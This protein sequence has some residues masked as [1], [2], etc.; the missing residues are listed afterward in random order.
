MI[1]SLPKLW[2]RS[3]YDGRG[4]SERCCGR[5]MLLSK[6]EELGA[7]GEGQFLLNV[8]LAQ[9]SRFLPNILYKRCA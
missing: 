1:S 9:A 4:D 3:V 5:S 7:A 8:T 6:T 2:L